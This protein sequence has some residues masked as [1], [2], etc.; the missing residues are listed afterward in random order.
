MSLKRKA[1]PYYL[2]VKC[3]DYDEAEAIIDLLVER[4]YTHGKP[5]Q[6]SR[7]VV[8]SDCIERTEHGRREKRAP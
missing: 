7:F 5:V 3:A 4:G 1:E 8:E 2:I 6:A